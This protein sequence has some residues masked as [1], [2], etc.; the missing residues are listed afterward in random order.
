[1]RVFADTA[2]PVSERVALAVLDL[3]LVAVLRQLA[4]KAPADLVSLEMPE[5][6]AILELLAEAF[7]SLHWTIYNASEE[8][9]VSE[10]LEQSMEFL[11][12]RAFRAAESHMNQEEGSFY[13]AG[14]EHAQAISFSGETMYHYDLE[15]FVDI[16]DLFLRLPNLTSQRLPV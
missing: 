4:L 5:R 16:P 10:V 14:R 15:N 9:D 3:L 1:M 6:Y 11:K 12:S 2:P 7:P 13:R 8:E